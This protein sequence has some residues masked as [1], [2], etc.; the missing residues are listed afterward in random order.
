MADG[1]YDVAD[2]RDVDPRSAPSRTSTGCWRWRRPS[3]SRCSST[4]PQPHLQRAPC[5]GRRGRRPRLSRTGALV[6]GPHRR[7]RR[8]PAQRL[9]ARSSVARPGPESRTAVDTCTC[10]TSA[11]PTS[12][13]QP[14]GAGRVRGEPAVLARPR[15]RRVPHRRGARA[16]PRTSPTRCATSARPPRRVMIVG[17]P[18]H[19]HWDRDDV[20]E[21]YRSWRRLL[22]AYDPPRIG[23]AR[24]GVS[25]PARR[26]AY[27]RPDEL[28]PGVQLRLPAGPVEAGR[29]CARS[30]TGRCTPPQRSARP[31]PGCCPTH[32][33]VRAATRYAPYD[34]RLGLRRARAAALLMLGPARLGLSL[35]GRKSS[36]CPRCST[37][38]RRRARTQS[39]CAPAGTSPGATD[40]GCRCPGSRPARRTASG[41]P[42]PG[43]RSPRDW[44][45]LCVQA[46]TAW[47]ARRSS[48]TVT[49]SR[50]G[51]ATAA[52]GRCTGGRPPAARCSRFARGLGAGLHRQ[53]RYG[54]PQAAAGRRRSC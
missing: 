53:S 21:I 2:Y 23:V 4:W 46:R 29:G 32:D 7:Q 36:G 45:R 38:R 43:C 42:A 48:S 31:R 39:G 25:S 20:H 14:G 44:G 6:F 41:R 27:V 50:C 30:S 11:S 9:G 35:P 28:A 40:L 37:C 17:G 12:T 13:G 3:G 1:G 52:A 24:P 54:G 47:P 18:D 34:A 16:G 26:G 19:P 8:T 49:R 5:S 10:S 33:V 22:D 51:A 15:G